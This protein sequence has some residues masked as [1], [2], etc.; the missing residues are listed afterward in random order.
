MKESYK[1]LLEAIDELS[2]MANRIIRKLNYIQTL[3]IYKMVEPVYGQLS[4]ICSYWSPNFDNLSQEEQIIVM[5]KIWNRV[6]KQN[7]LPSNID[8]NNN[9]LEKDELKQRV[10]NYITKNGN[11]IR[12]AD[13]F[14]SKIYQ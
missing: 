12:S 4:N 11:L 10:L 13:D 2:I 5:N 6:N 8:E 9:C 3:E 14:I 7:T 1:Q